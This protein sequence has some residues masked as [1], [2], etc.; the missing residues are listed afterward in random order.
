M[1]GHQSIRDRL[2]AHP[3]AKKQHQAYDRFVIGSVF[4]T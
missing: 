3:A 1:S 4:V 2:N